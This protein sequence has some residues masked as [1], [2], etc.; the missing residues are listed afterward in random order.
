MTEPIVFYDIASAS[1]G[2]WGP[3]TWKTRYTLNIKGIPYR[4]IAAP[5]AETL[6]DG[7]PMFN[8]PNTKTPVADSAAITRYLER[9]YDAHPG[10]GR[11]PPRRIQRGVHGDDCRNLNERSAA[12]FR[13]T[14]GAFLGADIDTLAPEGSAARAK[15]WAGVLKVF[16]TFAGWIDAGG[17]RRT[18]FTGGEELC[19][20]EVTIAG[21]TKFMTGFRQYEQQDVG[22]VLEL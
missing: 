19:Y 22:S 9:T 12:Y 18:Y 15:H 16:A 14:R 11:R 10:A 6:P 4:K 21:F 17:V 7:T 2:A 3:N 1:I 13:A 20:A 8:D 5:F